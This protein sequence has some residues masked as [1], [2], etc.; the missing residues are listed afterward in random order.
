M[1]VVV[2]LLSGLA[3][4]CGTENLFSRGDSTDAGTGAAAAADAAVDAGQQVS[5]A[6]VVLPILQSKCASCHASFGG[7]FRVVGQAA[8]DYTNALNYVNT[9]NPSASA[10][11]QKPTGQT[12]H[13]GGTVFATTS[14]EYT[15]ILGWIVGGAAP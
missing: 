14:A 2:Y 13:S 15:A 10:L 1:R 5:F 4:G 6:T 11:L 7:S 12:S 9:S 8:T 3:A